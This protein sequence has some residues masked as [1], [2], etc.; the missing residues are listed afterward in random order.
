MVDVYS[1]LYGRLNVSDP[2]AGQ[3]ADAARRARADQ[4]AGQA[5]Q[6]SDSGGG[7][8]A[9]AQAVTEAATTVDESTLGWQ[10]DAHKNLPGFRELF[11]RF[12]DA[13]WFVMIDDDT[14]MFMDNLQ[15]SLAHL[16]PD[17][18]HY[19]GSR[20]MFFGCD[21]VTRMG[22]GPGFAHGG[23]GIVLS[24]GAIKRLVDGVDA[25]I[26]KYKD[27]WAGD[28]RVGLCL[29]DLGISLTDPRG[30]HHDPP[31]RGFWFPP[32]ACFRPVSFHHLLPQQMQRLADLEARVRA[33]LSGTDRR[34]VTVADVYHDWHGADASGVVVA[35][36]D[37]RGGDFAIAEAPSADV[38]VLVCRA[39]ERCRSWT[40]DGTRCWLKDAVPFEEYREGAFAGVVSEHYVCQQ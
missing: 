11:S 30:F 9:A 10:A 20:T 23:S 1:G 19:I 38:C 32:D 31:S 39:T 2:L 16:D 22:D 26:V 36:A 40:F 27:C 35:N 37:R 21:G 8:D 7:G 5:Q 15:R 34:H 14:F 29:R 24:R 18:E 17:G 3:L 12:P 33:G 13:D 6:R 28:V 25:C 4:P